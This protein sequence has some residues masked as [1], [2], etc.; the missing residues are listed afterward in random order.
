MAF[1]SAGTARGDKVQGTGGLEPLG[2]G[3]LVPR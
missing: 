2:K 1:S 3:D